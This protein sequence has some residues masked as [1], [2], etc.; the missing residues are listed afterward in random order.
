MAGVNFSQGCY[1][2]LLL[3]VLTSAGAVA[4]TAGA[5]PATSA[6]VVNCGEFTARDANLDLISKL[7]QFALTYRDKLPDF[8]VQQTT[9]SHGP[10]STVVMTAQVTYHKGIE[11]QSQ[12]MVNG[13]PM[14][15][16]GRGNVDLRLTTNGEFGPLLI[17]LFEIPDMVAF[18]FRKA[19]TLLGMP[20]AV[21]DFELPKKKNK[22]WSVRD[23][24]GE[25]LNPEFHGH[26]WLET[27]SGRI[28]REEVEPVVD[29]R[30]TWI[31]SMKLSTDYAMTEVPGLGSFLLPVKSESK[32]CNGGP[33]YDQGCTTNTTVFHDYQKFT[34]TSRI[35]PADS[36]P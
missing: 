13:K 16:K 14:P 27:Q 4:Q 28:V 31:D 29:G 32:V 17:N 2:A 26:L 5:N 8:I 22:L 23:P 25:T 19:D 3:A 15:T 20:V 35:L 6:N 11:Q 12:R 24:K 34:A 9:T 36:Q 7:C 30:S 33:L 10:Q 18:K 21:F 1:R